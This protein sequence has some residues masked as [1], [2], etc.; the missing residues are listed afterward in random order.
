MARGFVVDSMKYTLSLEDRKFQQ[1]AVA[2]DNAVNK[3]AGSLKGNLTK[4]LGG[5]GIAFGAI[6]IGSLMKDSTLVAARTKVLGTV[7]ENVGKRAGY[8]VPYLDEVDRSIR[9]LGI[10]TQSARTLMI[11]FMQSELDVADAAK[12]ARAAQDLA[13]IAGMDSSQAAEQLTM[14]ISSQRMMLLKQFGIVTGLTEIYGRYADQMG[15]SANNLTQYQKKQAFLN[16]ILEEAAKVAGSYEA[17]MADAG[18]QLTSMPR[19]IQEFENA[20]GKGFQPILKTLIDVSKSELN[21]ARQALLSVF[22]PT[23]L[24]SESIVKLEKG[25]GGQ[26]ELV[27]HLAERYDQLKGKTHL[28]VEEQK[29][30]ETVLARLNKLAPEAA[31]GFDKYGKAIEFN[32][33]LIKELVAQD[34]RLLRIKLLEKYD[35][36]QDKLIQSQNKL[37]K[38][39]QRRLEIMRELKDFQEAGGVEGKALKDTEAYASFVQKLP[40]LIQPIWTTF[41]G[42]TGTIMDQGQFLEVYTEHFLSIREEAKLLKKEMGLLELSVKA[43]EETLDF[44]HKKSTGQ[45]ITPPVGKGDPNA[46][47]AASQ[48]I[49]TLLLSAKQD[50]L[51]KEGEIDI[52]AWKDIL[53]SRLDA[54]EVFSEENTRLMMAMWHAEREEAKQAIDEINS[55]FYGGNQ[56]AFPTFETGRFDSMFADPYQVGDAWKKQA[57]EIWG[58]MESRGETAITNISDMWTDSFEWIF[59][60]FDDDFGRF[61]DTMIYGFRSAFKIIEQDGSTALAFN[62]ANPLAATT[63]LMSIFQGIAG[64]FQDNTEASVAVFKS[65][66]EL[67]EAIDRLTDQVS[68]QSQTSLA[69][70]IEALEKALHAWESFKDIK[71]RDPDVTSQTIREMLDRMLEEVGLSDQLEGV[72]YSEL[73][74]QMQ[75]MVDALKQVGDFWNQVFTG[76]SMKDF[77]SALSQY[78]DLGYQELKTAIDYWVDI[79][80][81]TSEEQLRLYEQLGDIMQ[82]SQD[83]SIRDQANWNQIINDLENAIQEGTGENTPQTFR[84]VTTITESQANIMV[85]QLGSLMA[86]NR[87]GNNILDRILGVL[88]SG[89]TAIG[90]GTET[91]NSYTFHNTF[92]G[93]GTDGQAIA[94]E[95]MGQMRASGKGT[96]Q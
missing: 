80:S 13:V 23:E 3:L 5:L 62:T 61:I 57:E 68:G 30:L 67:T 48:A 83:W 70:Q 39:Q 37:G 53:Q 86:I 58:D 41:A 76:R 63:G 56:K 31:T 59:S 84:S 78:S 69:A 18:K 71:D 32:T 20:L 1:K 26:S 93:T 52:K 40:G 9:A 38:A 94:D 75:E 19:Y 35:A 79:F 4:A 42:L 81:L 55:F 24:L 22:D 44:L 28:N 90:G 8:A 49:Q 10:T 14:A 43:Y 89:T 36:I 15:L 51:Y 25:L 88:Q 11:R 95:L 2:A 27:N 73:G 92:Q 21:S 12:L 17:S 50:F 66:R 54:S 74:D 60:Q 87:E 96:I 47:L 64:I 46:E 7:L 29:E 85:G 82:E 33:T 6:K 77:E 45:E 34:E 65:Q 91:V 72:P 16:V